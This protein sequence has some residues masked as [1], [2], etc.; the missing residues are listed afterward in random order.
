[1]YQPVG[2]RSVVLGNEPVRVTGSIAGPVTAGGTGCSIEASIAYA[3][4]PAKHAQ[5]GTPVSIYILGE[6]IDGTVASAP[7]FDPAGA[8]IRE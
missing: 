1:M 6:W 2:G 4:L 5:P 7:L 8:R 3:C